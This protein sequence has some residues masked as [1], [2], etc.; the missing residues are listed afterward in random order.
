[1]FIK[2]FIAL[3]SLCVDQS[4][5]WLTASLIVADLSGCLLYAFEC[6][7]STRCLRLVCI[8]CP[9]CLVLLQTTGLLDM[10]QSI[11]WM[12]L[13]RSGSRL[14]QIIVRYVYARFGVQANSAFHPFGV[15]K[16]RVATINWRTRLFGHRSGPLRM[17]L[18]CSL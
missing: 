13:M 14:L 4:V 15:G 1:V 9:W 16:T 8:L 10:P 2:H 18:A 7:L 11:L 3:N 5:T 6:P 17:G 12:Y